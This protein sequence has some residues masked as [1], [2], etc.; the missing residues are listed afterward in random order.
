MYL[1]LDDY[2]DPCGDIFKKRLKPKKRRGSHSR[3][4]ASFVVNPKAVIGSLVYQ[5]VMKIIYNF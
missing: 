2:F 5:T 3:L 1:V 4:A